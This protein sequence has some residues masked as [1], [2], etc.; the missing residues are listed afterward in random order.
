M[1]RP[2][3]KSPGSP[4]TRRRFVATGSANMTGLGLLVATG[5]TSSTDRKSADRSDNGKADGWDD[6][7]AAVDGDLPDGGNL[8]TTCGDL[9]EPSIEGPFYSPGSPSRRSLRQ[10]GMEGVLFTLRGRVLTSD[11]TPVVGA[12]LDFWQADDDGAYDN[13]GFD[14][15]GHQFTDAQG[16]YSLETIIPGHYLNGSQYRPAHIHVKVGGAGLML[17]TTQL[18]FAGDPFN[19]IDPFLHESLIMPTTQTMSGAVA[20][21]F[22][23][24]V[25]QKA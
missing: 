2:L 17:L 14:L 25:P 8:P 20:A 23:F 22:D 3:E 6:M 12:F 7:D 9:T 18:Y 24:V 11:C 21:T 5:C 13:V 1:R 4:L 15:R 10:P 19:T 16:R